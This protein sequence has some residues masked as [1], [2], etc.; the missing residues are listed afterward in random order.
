MM[1]NLESVDTRQCQPYRRGEVRSFRQTISPNITREENFCSDKIGILNYAHF[2]YT[3]GAFIGEDFLSPERADRIDY[4][5]DGRLEKFNKRTRACVLGFRRPFL[6]DNQLQ[7]PLPG[8]CHNCERADGS[9]LEGRANSD[10]SPSSNFVQRH[11][12]RK[13]IFQAFAKT[14]N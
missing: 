5:G 1:W 6:I 3:S 7:I 14:L 8:W 2:I 13:I 10:P 4:S 9:A 12:I 11:N